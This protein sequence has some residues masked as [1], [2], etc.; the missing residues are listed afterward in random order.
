[1]TTTQLE[2]ATTAFGLR[3]SLLGLVRA[4]SVDNVQSQAVLAFESLGASLEVSNDRIGEAV[5]ALGGCK[6]VRIERLQLLIG[7]SGGGVAR[8]IRKS[9]GCLKAFL[10]AMACKNCFEHHEIGSILYYML[11]TQGILRTFP[12]SR[13]QLGQL[14]G[15]ISSYGE[16]MRP[17]IHFTEVSTAIKNTLMAI[18]RERRSDGANRKPITGSGIPFG[19]RRFFCTMTVQSI[20]EVLSAVFSLLTND[21][22]TRVTVSGYQ[23]GAWI[24]SLF[25]WLLPHQVEIQVAGRCMFGDFQRRLSIQLTLC[26]SFD[27]DNDACAW[28]VQGWRQQGPLDSL[29]VKPDELLVQSHGERVFS[30]FPWGAVKSI[31]SIAE[32]FSSEMIGLTG[33]LAGALV[34]LVVQDGVFTRDRRPVDQKPYTIPF[35]ELCQQRFLGDSETYVVHFG[36]DTD[37]KFLREQSHITKVMHERLSDFQH[38]REGLMTFF[39]HNLLTKVLY[40]YCVGTNSPLERYDIEKCLVAAA[41]ISIWALLQCNC[42]T[43]PLVRRLQK[44]DP[45]N[46]DP[47]TLLSRLLLASPAHTPHTSSN[48]F[49]PVSIREWRLCTFSS[50]RPGSSIA[51]ERCLASCKDGYVAYSVQLEQH[52]SSRADSLAFHVVPGAIQWGSED[53]KFDAIIEAGSSSDFRFTHDVL[54]I[55]DADSLISWDSSDPTSSHGLS[56][57]LTPESKHLL[58][59]TYFFWR[60]SKGVRSRRVMWSD[61]IYAL[62]G[63]IHLGHPSGFERYEKPPAADRNWKVMTFPAIL[64]WP[65]YDDREQ[66]AEADNSFHSLTAVGK[67]N[68]ICRFFAAGWAINLSSNQIQLFVPHGVSLD[69]CDK[70]VIDW[71]S[72]HDQDPWYLLW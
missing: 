50:F 45:D 47:V 43:T 48:T 71:Q 19:A 25:S 39:L 42:T 44:G 10:L 40:E 33:K 58:L 70:Y 53:T 23:S 68:S 54:V 8:E 64:N 34:V 16:I 38:E 14:V 11:A 21:D 9:S 66:E 46:D 2:V 57:M 37:S 69:E 62:A 13:E 27:D 36:W 7:L 1:M 28:V 60:L 63:A 61:S 52:S 32:D 24:A 6:S 30:R 29:I 59:E 12:T 56:T 49:E 67:R 72:R 35:R 26:D 3:D 22:V 4:A 41:Q 17:D 31:K 5:N 20:A 55:C 65:E 18:G 51:N 15:A